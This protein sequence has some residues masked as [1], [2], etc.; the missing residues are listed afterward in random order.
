MK[1]AKKAGCAV[2]AVLVLL[3]GLGGGIA[4]LRGFVPS[5]PGFDA[6][7]DPADETA[8]L[9]AA[10]G[11]ATATVAEQAGSETVTIYG[12]VCPSDYAGADYFADCFDTPAVGASY[13]LANGEIRVPAMG[14]AVAGDD[15]LVTPT[16]PSGMAPGT[17]VLQAIA[18]DAIV[19]SGGFAVPAAACTSSEG[20]EVPVTPQASEGVG[21]LLA[22]DLQAGEDLR[23]DVYFVPLTLT[24]GSR[25]GVVLGPADGRPG[26]IIGHGGTI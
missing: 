7:R 5:L 23:C 22:F 2:I 16:V 4:Y 6:G 13:T 1:N 11:T 25:D 19:G 10:T 15:G 3:L 8:T 12:A 24:L 26:P 17:V 18:P 20:R 9:M 21:E 14:V